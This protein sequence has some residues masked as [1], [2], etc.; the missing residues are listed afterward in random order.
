PGRGPYGKQVDRCVDYLLANTE[1]S[2]FIAIR[3][4]R[5]HG[6]MYGHGFAAMFLAEVYGMSTRREIREKLSKAIAIIVNSQSS[7]G[8]WRYQPIRRDADI[9]VT[10]C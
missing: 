9:S 4:A 7:E 10:I 8:G 6:P 3:G 1:A 2:G 5:T